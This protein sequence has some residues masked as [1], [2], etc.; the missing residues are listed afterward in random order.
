MLPLGWALAIPA[1][2]GLAGI[3]WA[4]IIASFISA[5]LLLGRFAWLAR[6]PL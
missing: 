6:D 3:L 4:V 2:L 5:G 1:G